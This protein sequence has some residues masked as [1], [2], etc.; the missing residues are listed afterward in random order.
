VVYGASHRAGQLGE[1]GPPRPMQ[2]PVLSGHGLVSKEPPSV[3][4]FD[5]FII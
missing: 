1:T 3:V 4:I 5:I 2:G